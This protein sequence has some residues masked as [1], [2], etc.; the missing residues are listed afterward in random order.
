M[1][2]KCPQET[3]FAKGGCVRG[4]GATEAQRAHSMV[5]SHDPR[6]SWLFGLAASEGDPG[7]MEVGLGYFFFGVEVPRGS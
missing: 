2:S 3:D 1:L 5:Q 6:G 4:E 7:L